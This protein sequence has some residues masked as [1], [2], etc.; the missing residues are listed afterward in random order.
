M[1]KQDSE[2]L[3]GYAQSGDHIPRSLHHLVD[4]EEHS[5]AKSPVAK[6]KAFERITHF[7]RLY[8]MILSQKSQRL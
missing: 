2:D 8:M 6:K 5:V 3:D 4:G 1:V 7:K